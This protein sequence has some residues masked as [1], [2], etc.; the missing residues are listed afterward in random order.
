M[1]I[2]NSV[3][4]IGNGAA[5]P[6][7]SRSIKNNDSQASGITTPSADV[8]INS[9][10]S[11]SGDLANTPVIDTAKI[12]EIKQAIA[13]GRFKVHPEIV[14]DRLLETVRQLINSQQKA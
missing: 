6:A 13:E 10:Q 7:S 2:D 1:K 12:E 3:K 4:N 8:Q 5:S 14:A 11:L 9:L